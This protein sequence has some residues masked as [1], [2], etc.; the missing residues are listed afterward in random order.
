MDALGP[1]AAER[2]TCRDPTRP[3][4]EGD[5]GSNRIEVPGFEPNAAVRQKARE[6]VHP[7]LFGDPSPDHQKWPRAIIWRRFP[8]GIWRIEARTGDEG[9]SCGN[10]R[11]LVTRHAIAP[12]SAS[13]SCSPISIT[14]LVTCCSTISLCLNAALFSTLRNR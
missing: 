10:W 9:S 3:K 6:K 8:H 11:S 2:A 7:P 13:V 12:L 5:R 1:P 14:W 4:G